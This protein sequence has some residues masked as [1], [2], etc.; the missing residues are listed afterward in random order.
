MV[1]TTS[2]EFRDRVRDLWSDQT[3]SMKMIADE[4]GVTKNV[5]AGLRYR[6]KLPTRKNE[7]QAGKKFTINPN[8]RPKK[9][10]KP[11][12]LRVYQPPPKPVIVAPAQPVQPSIPTR[13]VRGCCR[14]PMWDKGKPTHMYCDKP[15]VG[16]GTLGKLYCNTHA[17]M[18]KR[19]DAA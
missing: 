7:A 2:P 12:A 18:A 19:R 16:Y 1:D 13:I 10:I 14:W 5:I 6:M 9:V 17:V 15:T 11:R 4:L 8:A 3:K